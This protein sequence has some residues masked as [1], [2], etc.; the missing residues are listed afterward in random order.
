MKLIHLKLFFKHL[1]KNKLYSGITI[2]GFAVALMFVFLLSIYIKQELS[3]DEFHEKKNRLFVLVSDHGGIAPPVGERLKNSYPEIEAYTRLHADVS[4]LFGE[5]DMK[6]KCKY[7][8]ADSAFF[9]MFSFDL[10]EGDRKQVL[11]TGNS[12][13]LSESYVKK[14]FSNESPIGKS[15]KI[16]FRGDFIVTGIMK[17]FPVNTHFKKVDAI[18]NFD[19]LEDIWGANGL[20]ATYSNSSFG[21]YLLTK[22]NTNL[23]SK[24]GEIVEDFKKDYWIFKRG[25]ATKLFL[26]PLST[27]YFK[28]PSNGYVKSNNITFIRVLSAIVLLILFLSVLN[29]INLTVAQTNEKYKTSAIKQV[30]GNSKKQLIVQYLSESVIICLMAS[31]LGFLLSLSAKPVFNK[32]LNTDLNYIIHFNTTLIVLS[33]LVVFLIGI[34]AGIIPALLVARLNPVEAVKGLSRSKANLSYRNMLIGFQFTIAICLLICTSIIIK[35]TNFLS[36]FRPGFD[37]ENILNIVNEIS[38]D[39]RDVFK[40]QLKKIPGVEDVCYTAG[41]PLDGGNNDSF[42]YNGRPM[43]FQ[44]FRVDTIFFSFFNIPYTKTGAAYSKDAIWLNEIATLECELGELPTSFKRYGNELPVYGIVK[45]LH[46]N[47]LHEKIGPLIIRQLHPNAYAWDIF[48]KVNS[49]NVLTT[50]SSIKSEYENITNGMPIDCQFIDQK[51]NDW[52]TKE[53]KLKKI[54]GYFTILSILMAALGMLAIVSYYVKN[55][56][57]AIGIR[58]VNGARIREILAMLNL[59]FIQVVVI[60]FIVASPIAWYAMGKWLETYAYKTEISWWIFILVGAATMIIALITVSM[61]SWRVASKN[62]VE[63]LRYE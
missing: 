46:F 2:G 42:D 57:K 7:L 35:Q 10:I 13:V 30:L 37:K 60:S 23:S 62:P 3:V 25:Y 32:L 16:G 22:P 40:E 50:V 5:N 21:L 11:R 47:S 24:L 59:N 49:N 33:I 1:V 51:M 52:Y 61:Q 38:S 53:A 44:D 8:L 27:I 55:N 4:V 56:I 36:E 43:S 58:K 19:G 29:Y 48:V 14:H 6:I 17:D 18:I 31:V 41:S 20:L 39:K 28:A 34:I 54:V 45:K 15:L 12:I 9:S 63:S 26:E